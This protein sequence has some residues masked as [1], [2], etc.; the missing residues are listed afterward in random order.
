MPMHL[1][2]DAIVLSSICSMTLQC[3][4]PRFVGTRKEDRK[5]ARFCSSVEQEVDKEGHQPSLRE[6]AQELLNW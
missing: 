5:E 6:E 1:L 2:F 4:S 3:L